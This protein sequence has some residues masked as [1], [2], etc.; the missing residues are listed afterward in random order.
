ML[1]AAEISKLIVHISSDPSTDRPA[2]A[3]RELASGLWESGAIAAPQ[4]VACQALVP[5]RS[6]VLVPEDHWIV[7]TWSALPP[8]SHVMQQ[9]PCASGE[10]R[11]GR[12]ANLFVVRV[13]K[14][15][16][17]LAQLKLMRGV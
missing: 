7:Q 8:S 3:G 15:V 5:E 13:F 17:Y 2:P 11:L 6:C 16:K 9:V 1:P 4:A 12:R 10:F 14:R